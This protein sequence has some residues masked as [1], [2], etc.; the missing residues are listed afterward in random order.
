MTSML[1]DEKLNFSARLSTPRRFGAAVVGLGMLAIAGATLA[2]APPQH[3]TGLMGSA[4]AS[5][6]EAVAP[7]SMAMPSFA[8]LVEQLK[9]AV[10]S[11]YVDAEVRG[12]RVA[13]GPDL[14]GDNPF[15][16]FFRGFGE[17]GRQGMPM[18]RV[19]AQGSGFFISADGY[20]LTNNHVVERAKRVQVKTVDGK[21]L[22]AK[23]VGADRQT[24]LAVL[25]VDRPGDYKFVS[26]ASTAPR[27][28]DWVLAMGNPYGL[29]GTVTAGIVSA[30]GRDIGA[31][32]YN[33]FLQIDAPVNKGN[34]GGPTFNMQG[35]VVGINTAIYS[36]SGGS[37]GI[38]FAIPADTAKSVA[39]QLKAKGA[40]NRGWIGIVVQPVTADIAES[41]GL[42]DAKGALINDVQPGGPAAKAG[43]RSGDVVLSVEGAEVK[44]SRDL[45]R[46]IG[47]L[48][49]GKS[50]KLEIKR[51]GKDQTFTLTAATYPKS[52]ASLQRPGKTEHGDAKLGLSIAPAS[53]VDGAGSQGLAVI[54]VDPNGV[55]AEKGVQQGDVILDVGGKEVATA[56]DLTS[57]VSDARK[58][59]KRSILMRVKSA[60]GTRYVALPIT[61]Q[62]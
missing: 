6:I 32:P 52:E 51:G 29:G 13:G 41:L 43:L 1:P 2:F 62:S 50:L 53:A 24:D 8:G 45:A 16:F 28:G 36:P 23:V 11:V 38:A 22:D 26:F 31:G 37:V 9:P 15:E 21:T 61:A 35:E 20:I 46:R 54:Q 57:A 12:A 40:V 4:S 19:Q 33:D 25:K 14:G 55:A 47:E 42:A 34:S 44:D 60:D 27:V 10:V 18:Q 30:S 48:G 59:G 49:P 58:S 7:S 39:E 56:E 17:P 3:A 5:A